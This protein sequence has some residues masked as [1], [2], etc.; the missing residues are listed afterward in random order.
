MASKHP[1]KEGTYSCTLCRYTT[2]NCR[3]YLAHV[4]CHELEKTKKTNNKIEKRNVEDNESKSSDET[5]NFL[6]TE[7]SEEAV[8]T[9]GITI[10]AGFDLQI[11]NEQTCLM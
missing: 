7:H 1:G 2:I 5:Q 3:S 6:N 9:G 10:P 4:K 8:D 11:N